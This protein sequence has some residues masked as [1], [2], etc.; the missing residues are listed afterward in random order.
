LLLIWKKM[1]F[2]SSPLLRWIPVISATLFAAAVITFGT[3]LEGYSQTLHP[4]ALPGAKGFANALVFNVLAFMLPGALTAFVAIGLRATLP[5]QAAWQLRLGAQ[6]LLLAA[7]AFAAMGLLPLD[8]RDLENNASRLHGTAWMLWCMAF[9]VG[10]LMLGFGWLRTGDKRA[11]WTFAVVALALLAEFFL[12][13][14]IA[15]GIAQ[16]VAFAAW[17]GWLIWMA[18]RSAL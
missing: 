6:L 11:T 1:K 13:V 4:V 17:W 9:A 8:T 3:M 2:F 10:G 7:L 12:P 5:A 14:L 15:P 18:W 16:R